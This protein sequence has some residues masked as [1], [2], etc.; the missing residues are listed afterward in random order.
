MVWLG[1]VRFGWL[2]WVLVLVWLWFGSVVWVVGFVG[3]L[4]LVWLVEW[5]GWSRWLFRFGLVVWLF[6]C[7]VVLLF[8]CLVVCLVGRLVVCLVGWLVG[9]W[10]GWVSD[11]DSVSVSAWVWVWIGWLFFWL[12]GTLQKYKLSPNN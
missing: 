9:C 12:V 2:S 7:S 8:G 1:S 6:G 3:R 10:L 11:S 4:G 5:F